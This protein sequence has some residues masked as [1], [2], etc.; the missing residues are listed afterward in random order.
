MSA[1]LSDEQLAEIR[2]RAEAATPGPWGWRGNT[3]VRDLRL[4]ALHSG[5]LT[6]MDFTRW[7]MQRARPRFALEGVMHDGDELV[8]YEVHR[9]GWTRA[10][11]KPYRADVDGIAHPDAEFIARARM[12]VPALLAEVERLRAQVETLTAAES[13]ASQMVGDQGDRA[14]DLEAALAATGR[15]LSSFIFDSDDPGTDALGAQW[16]YHQVM[17]Q[18]DDPFAQPRAFRASVF[19]EA[20]KSAEGLNGP[21]GEEHRKRPQAYLDGYSDGVQDVVEHLNLLADQAAEGRETR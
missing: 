16:L 19:E 18:A 4:S 12:D 15:S 21:G 3:E 5:L 13:T 14:A 1:P 10:E 6:V 9:L 11:E 17:P 2:A 8:T 20:A 7:G